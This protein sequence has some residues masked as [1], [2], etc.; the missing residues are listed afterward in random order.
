ML[1]VAIYRDSGARTSQFYPWLRSS[2]LHTL[3]PFKSPI[4]LIARLAWSKSSPAQIFPDDF[5]FGATTTVDT[6][7]VG[8]SMY[9]IIPSSTLRLNCSSSCLRTWSGT[10]RCGYADW[11]D[12]LTD[13]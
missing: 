12:V 4:I 13:V 2:F 11:R 10:I 1:N 9:S 6:Q 5:G 8:P 7:G 3:A